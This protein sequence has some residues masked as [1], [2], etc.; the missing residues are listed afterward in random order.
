[1]GILDYIRGS[2]SIFMRDIWKD[3]PPLTVY[4]LRRSDPQ[5]TLWNGKD[6]PGSQPLSTFPALGLYW[7]QLKSKL[8]GTPDLDDPGHGNVQSW[9]VPPPHWGWGSPSSSSEIGPE[10]GAGEWAAIAFLLSSLV[11]GERPVGLVLCGWWCFF[12]PAWVNG[13]KPYMDVCWTS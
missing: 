1:M 2:F 5:P 7:P 13:Q 9:S 10:P 3:S 6:L 11:E 4:S 12:L 8:T